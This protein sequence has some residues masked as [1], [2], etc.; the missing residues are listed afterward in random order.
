MLG[1]QSA[2]AGVRQR[3]ALTQGNQK[4][5]IWV[6]TSFFF[7]SFAAPLSFGASLFFG[8]G[9]AS[10]GDGRQACQ[11]CNRT[12]QP[13]T[14]AQGSH[15]HPIYRRCRLGSLAVRKPLTALTT[16]HS[17]RWSHG[18]HSTAVQHNCQS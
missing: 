12:L 16:L 17:I 8:F 2:S 7:S 13:V 5:M 10:C 6:R 15:A 9:S 14:M 18:T 4:I 11:R 3:G 1:L